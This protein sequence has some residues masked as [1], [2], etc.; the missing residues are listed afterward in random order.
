MKKGNVYY[1][2]PTCELAVAN[3]SFS[4]M[5]PQLL[6]QMENDL[7]I[8]PTIFCNK[9]DYVLTENP[10][11]LEFQIY[12]K[13]LGLDLPTFI[14]LSE[15]ENDNSLSF[16]SVV[17]WGWSPAAHFK[18]KNLKL[19]CSSEFQSSPVFEWKEEHRLL[20]ERS[21]SLNLLDRILNE[22]SMDWLISPTLTGIIV[23]DYREIESILKRH[24]SVV[25]KAPLS[26]SGRGIQI[27]RNQGLNK[28][29]EQWISG[30]LKQQQ[31][32]IVEPLLDKL[33]DISFQFEIL[34]DSQI[35]YYG[36]SLFETNSNGQYK[37][38]YIHPDL[39]KLLPGYNIEEVTNQIEATSTILKEA[40]KTSRYAEH[41]AGF[42]GIDAIFFKNGSKLMMQPCIEVSCR[43][44]MGILSLKLEGLIHPEISGKFEI[45]RL[46]TNGK[47]QENYTEINSGKFY[48]KSI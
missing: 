8:L 5:P 13:E 48:P 14:Q 22:Y 2:N 4:Y 40:L 44:N 36:F 31:Y 21:S 34:H 27:I 39:R 37:G 15:L 20:Y 28:S 33:L 26:S 7:A 9:N 47:K 38:T 46:K 35:V 1:F 43:M 10:P 16:D 42:L 32:L 18:L 17:P 19:K 11:T 3:G 25:I 23:K 6:K 45:N 30:V 24:S 12:L 41:Y 29:N